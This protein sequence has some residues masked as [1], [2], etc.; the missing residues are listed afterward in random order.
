MEGRGFRDLYESFRAKNTAILGVSF[1]S[2]EKN[3]K[4]A[5]K[6]EFPFPLLCD[7]ERKIG[8]AYG[9]CASPSARFADRI[10]YVIDS[11]GRVAQAYPKV[12][13]KS[14]PQEVLDS[15]S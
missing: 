6:Q 11:N 4:F 5:R 13:P 2:I 1:D 7:T 12:S 14:H 15:L 8:M 3:A 10:S 9:A